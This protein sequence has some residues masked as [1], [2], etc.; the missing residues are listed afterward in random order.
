[1]GKLAIN[2]EFKRYKVNAVYHPYDFGFK[3]FDEHNNEIKNFMGEIVFYN[4]GVEIGAEVEVGLMINETQAF[5]LDVMKVDEDGYPLVVRP[6]L[7][8]CLLM[9]CL[10]LA[11]W[12][13]ASEEEKTMFGKAWHLYLKEIV[14]GRI[15]YHNPDGLFIDDLLIPYEDIKGEEDK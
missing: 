4:D 7:T 13:R 5:I 10:G 1:M 2:K 6:H 8:D 11:L 12:S 14:N 15:K 9:H 3:F